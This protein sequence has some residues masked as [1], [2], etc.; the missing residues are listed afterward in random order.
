MGA[1][2]GGGLYAGGGGGVGGGT[3]A[4]GAPG[5]DGLSIT[6]RSQF[7]S[8]GSY[9]INDV[10]YNSGSS[11]ICLVSNIGTGVLNS[12]Y[13]NIV[14]SSGGP[15]RQGDQGA[16]GPTGLT[17]ASGAAGANGA[18]GAMGASGARGA[19]A[20][21]GLLDIQFTNLQVGQVLKW[22]GI[23]WVNSGDNVG[24]GAG[25][26]TLEDLT[27]VTVTNPRHGQSL[28]YSANDAQFYNRFSAFPIHNVRDYG[29]VGDGITDDFAAVRLAT[30]TV[31]AS[32]G[33]LYF[34]GPNT[35]R[36]LVNATNSGQLTASETNVSPIINL[37][38]K[39]VSVIADNGA[40]VQVVSQ[41]GLSG[42]TPETTP[43]V[44]LFGLYA[45][46]IYFD[47]G[48]Y[49]FVAT[50]LGS[51]F[52]GDGCNGY[53]LYRGAS[54]NH[55][56]EY[57]F[58]SGFAGTSYNSGVL[59]S[60]YGRIEN[61]TWRRCFVHAWGGATKDG[62]VKCVGQTVFDSCDFEQRSGVVAL[63]EHSHAIELFQPTWN[64]ITNC[65]FKFVGG[66]VNNLARPIYISGAPS[67]SIFPGNTTT[68]DNCKYLACNNPNFVGLG[69][70]G[71]IFNN[72]ISVY[73]SGRTSADYGGIEI[74]SAS[75]TS[76]TAQIGGKILVDN[77]IYTT[78][79]NC[80]NTTLRVFNYATKFS[81]NSCIFLNP[82]NNYPS[83]VIPVILSGC[84]GGIFSNC[85]ID[86]TSTL[87]SM[88]INGCSDFMIGSNYFNVEGGANVLNV[89]FAS[90]LD[91]QKNVFAGED[92]TSFITIDGGRRLVFD[93]NALRNHGTGMGVSFTVNNGLVSG[94]L[95][96]NNVEYRMLSQAIFNAN[97]KIHSMANHWNIGQDGGTG[98]FIQSLYNTTGI[99]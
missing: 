6:W 88:V 22:N 76:V 90:G 10:V 56:F 60:S 45:D 3:G 98:I 30:A 58:I 12:V 91:V 32:G 49:H 85:N 78:L 55:I 11:Y 84:Q 46:N 94:S 87:D 82:T 16:T 57:M 65:L 67:T 70:R 41:L 1:L 8:T 15:G 89:I 51:L 92:F 52:T 96:R 38:R 2:Y 75:G 14:A 25:A 63:K 23:R 33:V 53:P 27:D 77:A 62:F 97:N 71:A 81:A 50:G 93:S 19:T 61:A 34:P 66:D 69:V 80:V 26:A 48:L 35:Y 20:L 68:V 83:P 21:S 99:F 9:S 72:N 18:S 54:Q 64:N 44:P 4:P 31:N 17:G 79:N 73:I 42:L 43:T 40:S 5:A 59:S 74:S 13:W 36:I 24:S 86:N 29:A 95:V 39:N 28:V 47:G 37:T 7:L